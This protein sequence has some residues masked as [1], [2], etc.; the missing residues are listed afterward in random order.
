MPTHS[1]ALVARDAAICQ[2]EAHADEDW[3]VAAL[4]AVRLAALH[5]PKFTT[6]QVW[7]MIAKD[8]HDGRAMGAIMQRAAKQ[9]YIVATNIWL[10]SDSVTN[11]ARPQRVWHSQIW[12][13]A[14]QPYLLEI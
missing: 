3:R 1:E 10:P 11:H 7:P 9:G 12:T 5:L 13:G 14:I 6:N 8:T 4:E 2:V